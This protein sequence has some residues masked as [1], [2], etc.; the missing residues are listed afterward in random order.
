M[1]LTGLFLFELYLQSQILFCGQKDY[2]VLHRT[3][4][5]FFAQVDA[6]VS[7]FLRSVVCLKL[8]QVQS[9]TGKICSNTSIAQGNI[10]GIFSKKNSKNT[11]F[12]QV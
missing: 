9:L 5:N 1:H 12:Y 6:R 3:Q 4:S 8:T 11:A 10:S 2:L 7:Y